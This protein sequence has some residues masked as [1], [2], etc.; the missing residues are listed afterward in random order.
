MG[1]LRRLRTLWVD[2]FD[3]PLTALVEG[4]HDLGHGRQQFG[5]GDFPLEMFAQGRF[6]LQPQALKAI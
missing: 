1:G 3:N 4:A 5:D 6:R 2:S